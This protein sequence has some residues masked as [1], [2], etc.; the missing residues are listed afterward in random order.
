[1]DNRN[2]LDTAL[3]QG[4]ISGE[5]REQLSA[6]VN[7]E[8][9]D[10]EER[11]KPVGTFNEIFVTFGVIM[12]LS[13]MSGLLGLLIASPIHVCLASIV[14]AWAAC[15]WFHRGKRFRL[16]IIFGVLNAAFGVSA[17]LL[18]LM[19]GDA[20]ASFFKTEL[21]VATTILAL[22][23]GLGMLALGAYRFRIPFLMLPIAILFT[24]IVT[25]AAKHTDSSLSYRLLLGV[26]GLC[27]LA[28]AIQ[29]DLRDPER[30]KRW[31]DYA[32]WS[33]IVGSPL[34]VHSLF[35]SILLDNDSWKEADSMVT[36]L[37][38]IGLTLAVSFVG[39]LLNRRALILSTLIYVAFILIRVMKGISIDHAPFIIFATLLLIGG[40]VTALGSRWQQVRRR[41]ISRLPEYSWL[42]RLPPS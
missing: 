4:I 40:Y 16:P 25:Y 9:G 22:S 21:P 1:M 15:V 26:S 34:F 6:L 11:F 33:Y 2:L 19:T 36:W 12:L 24:I 41:I 35:L 29:F 30:N 14:M 17:A 7:E 3:A 39:L 31:S 37:V 8:K 38:M 23:G 13:A 32:F 27:I 18:M 20:S 28:T 42:K 10:S 5:Q